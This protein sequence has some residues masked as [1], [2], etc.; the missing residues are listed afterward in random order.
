MV[1]TLFQPYFCKKLFYYYETGDLEVGIDSDNQTKKLYLDLIILAR[2]GPFLGR[3]LGRI[4]GPAG[5]AAL[6]FFGFGQVLDKLKTT[7]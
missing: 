3:V 6:I 1:E 5:R 4:F 2:P 7:F